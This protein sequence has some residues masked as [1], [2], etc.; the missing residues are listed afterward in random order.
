LHKFKR[1]APY[2]IL[3]DICP[4]L[5][6]HSSP[7]R[8]CYVSECG[9]QHQGRDGA[10]EEDRKARGCISCCSKEEARNGMVTPQEEEEGGLSRTHM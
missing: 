10:L 4:P 8:F 5:N 3:Q 1:V 7:K 9:H 2:N 6:S